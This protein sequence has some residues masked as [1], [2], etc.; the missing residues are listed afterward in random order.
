M[1]KLKRQMKNYYIKKY[2]KLLEHWA[3]ANLI[4]TL[5]KVSSLCVALLDAMGYLL[6]FRI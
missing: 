3:A 4:S 5:S 1:T 2:R 6:N